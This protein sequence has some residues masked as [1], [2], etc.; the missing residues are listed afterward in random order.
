MGLSLGPLGLLSHPRRRLVARLTL[1]PL[2]FTSL[3]ILARQ[4]HLT[5]LLVSLCFRRSPQFSCLHRRLPLPPSPST[6]AVSN[7]NS[8]A[9]SL[10]SR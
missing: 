3:R 8:H 6:I 9:N 5:P 1:P 7:L 4:P 2:S 10:A